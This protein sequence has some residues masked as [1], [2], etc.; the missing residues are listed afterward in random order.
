MPT[1]RMNII[2][3][4]TPTAEVWNVPTDRADISLG[5][6]VLALPMSEVERREGRRAVW[7]LSFAASEDSAEARRGTVHSLIV[8]SSEPKLTERNI[9]YVLHDD[10]P[11][12][13][14]DYDAHVRRMHG[15]PRDA[16][17]IDIP[18]PFTGHIRRELRWWEVTA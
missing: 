12:F 1:P 10:I 2:T 8:L 3:G 6:L 15:A 14:A 9:A 17:V 7:V 16:V 13:A 4:L 18:T 5:S 11:A